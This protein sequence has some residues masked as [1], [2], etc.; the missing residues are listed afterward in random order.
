M[1]VAP[2]A[3]TVAMVLIITRALQISPVALV[4]GLHDG[5]VVEDRLLG[6]DPLLVATADIRILQG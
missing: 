1:R 4:H 3:V 6:D 5:S 2:N